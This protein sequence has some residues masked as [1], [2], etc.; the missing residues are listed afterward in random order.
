MSLFSKKSLGKKIDLKSR[1]DN[2][3]NT[4]LKICHGFDFGYLMISILRV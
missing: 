2:Y 3:Y 4:K 1:F